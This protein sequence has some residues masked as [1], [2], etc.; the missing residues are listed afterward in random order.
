MKK[1]ASSKFITITIVLLFGILFVVKFAGP[2]ML[3]LY[4]ES[5]IG[6]C[7]KIPILCMAP[8]K[9]IRTSINKGYIPE[10]LPYK[11][12]DM[13]IYLPRGFTVV[14]QGITKY[15][16]K[17]YNY[18]HKGAVIYLLYKE[19]NFFINLFPE[20]KKQGTINDYEFI[21]RTMYARVKSIKNLSDVFF[22]IMKSI[23]TPDLG[24]QNNVKM[25]EFKIDSKRGFINYNLTKPDYYF[26]C[27]VVDTR[28]SF[29]KIYIKDKGGSLDLDKVLAIISTA[30]KAK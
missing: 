7:Q 1:N 30:N 15:Y 6:T 13:E 25:I 18:H 26:D 11:F 29:F 10:L 27:N 24:N 2:S 9:E 14:Q 8:E 17:K 22:V 16:Y 19:P 21:K 4:I 3:R 23:F 28:G 12:P 20:S 5:G